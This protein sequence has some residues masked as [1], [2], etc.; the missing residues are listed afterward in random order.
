MPFLPIARPRCR[1]VIERLASLSCCLSGMVRV[2]LHPKVQMVDTDG[3]FP[4]QSLN[5][6]TSGG[7]VEW[8]TM[9]LMRAACQR[10]YGQAEHPIDNLTPSNIAIVIL[11]IVQLTCLATPFSRRVT[12]LVFS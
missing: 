6:E 8:G 2:A 12:G 4:V 10:V 7:S 11:T 5:R 1:P 3:L 9:F